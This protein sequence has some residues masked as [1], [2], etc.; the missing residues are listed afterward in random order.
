[1]LSDSTT[2]YPSGAGGDKVSFPSA[3]GEGGGVGTGDGSGVLARGGQRCD[4]WC[5][6]VF[7]GGVELGVDFDFCANA[8]TFLAPDGAGKEEGAGRGE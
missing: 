2:P 1:M 8:D 3:G 6:V 7:L 5:G 4:T